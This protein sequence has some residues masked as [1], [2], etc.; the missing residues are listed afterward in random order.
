MLNS[1]LPALRL[2]KFLIIMEL[3]K[4][5]QIKNLC[6][7]DDV[8]GNLPTKQAFNISNEKWK[9]LTKQQKSALAKKLYFQRHKRINLFFTKEQ[10]TILEKKAANLGFKPS[11]YV[12]KLALDNFKETDKIP[13]VDRKANI[14]L[15]KLGANINQIARMVNTFKDKTN[16]Q[17]ILDKL[18]DIDAEIHNLKGEIMS[19]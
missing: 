19:K 10:F 2:D 13:R 6:I 17:L 1:D 12:K 18:Q 14:N 15:S 7:E 3:M 4:N 8:E 16:Q 11:M 5:G 9:L